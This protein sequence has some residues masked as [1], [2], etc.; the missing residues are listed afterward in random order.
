M[1]YHNGINT[2]VLRIQEQEQTL[3]L[4]TS[5]TERCSLTFKNTSSLMINLLMKS[6]YLLKN[7]V[8]Q[9]KMNYPKSVRNLLNKYTSI[10]ISDIKKSAKSAV[11]IKVDVSPTFAFS[12][13]GSPKKST[14]A[15][16]NRDTGRLPLESESIMLSDVTDSSVLKEDKRTPNKGK[17]PLI[18]GQQSFSPLNSS[19][20]S[21]ISMQ[22]NLEQPELFSDLGLLISTILHELRCEEE[23]LRPDSFHQYGELQ[24]QFK[25]NMS[26]LSGC[27]MKD[28]ITPRYG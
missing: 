17:R 13:S 5:K 8:S 3:S 23:T 26:Q 28:S 6:C 27:F 18:R 7:L 22:P 10:E 21:T 19:R 24:P 25:I 15:L 16:K 12:G 14:P 20:Q 4:I 9:M 1:L 11:V 2:L